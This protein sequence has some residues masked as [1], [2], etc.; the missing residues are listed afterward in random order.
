MRSRDRGGTSRPVCVLPFRRRE[1]MGPLPIAQWQAAL[2]H[3]EMSL[4]AATRA[5]DRAEERWELAVAPSAN[6]GEAPPSLDRLDA[7]LTEWET[8][9]RAAEE[10]TASVEHELTE[11]AAAVTRWRAHFAEWEELVK[12][13]EHIT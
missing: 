9:L 12:R 5:L 11:R 6:E 3:M 4:T 1:P 8:R 2:D 10:V 7:R 13:K